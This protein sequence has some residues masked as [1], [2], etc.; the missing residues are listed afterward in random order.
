MEKSR[1]AHFVQNCLLAIVKQH[2]PTF[3]SVILKPWIS[4]MTTLELSSV[5]YK[6]DSYIES[7][8]DTLLHR[9]KLVT[10]TEAL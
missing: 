5:T 1:Q 6:T 4:I 10:F 9:E 3:S 2:S 7:E 8:T